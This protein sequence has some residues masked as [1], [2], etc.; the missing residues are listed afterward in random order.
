MTKLG[1]NDKPFVIL[2]F[3]NCHKKAQIMS[4]L[5]LGQLRSFQPEPPMFSDPGGSPEEIFLFSPKT[6][7]RNPP[8]KIRTS[9]P[10]TP[11]TQAQ[12]IRCINPTISTPMPISRPIASLLYG[13]QIFS[14]CFGRA[15]LEV[16]AVLFP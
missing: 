4:G 1:Q 12:K 5:L 6:F 11:I 8:M 3:A 16:T 10:I 9:Q 7:M 14:Y 13:T 15:V 2:S